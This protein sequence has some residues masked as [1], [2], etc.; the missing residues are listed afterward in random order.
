MGGT[1]DIQ[2]AGGAYGDGC[3]DRL[4]WLATKVLRA[5]APTSCATDVPTAF[6]FSTHIQ[7]I[8]PGHEEIEL[9]VQG[10]FVSITNASSPIPPFQNFVNS[11]Q[12]M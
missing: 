4:V 8:D 12:K 6:A 2:T 3:T 7:H 5:F 1:E 11:A 9:L 10:D